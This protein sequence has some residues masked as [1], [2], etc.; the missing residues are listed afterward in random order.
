M[1]EL[2]YIAGLR[3]TARPSA[4][5]TIAVVW[6]VLNVVAVQFFGLSAGEGIVGALVATVT[7]WLFEL[8][9]QLGHSIAAKRTGYPM[10]GVYFWGPIATSIYPKDEPPLPGKIHIRRA[11]GGPILS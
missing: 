1:I 2:G 10:R 4:L 8:V 6:V 5:I 3:I 11:L 9:H 7:H